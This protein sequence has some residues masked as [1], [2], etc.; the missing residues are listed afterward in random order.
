MMRKTIGLASMTL[1]VSQY[2]GP[3]TPWPE[4]SSPSEG[5]TPVTHID[6]EQVAAGLKGT[7][8]LRCLDGHYRPHED[9]IFGKVK[10]R[11]LWIRTDAIETETSESKHLCSGNWCESD[12]EK[13]GPNGETHILS[14]VEAE[15]GW[16][17]LQ[18]WGFMMVGGERRYARNIIVKKGT[19]E[20]AEIRLVYDF[21]S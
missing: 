6:I 19:K 17:A 7:T 15:A 10:G 14:H 11:S 13:A 3:S 12:D 5:S 1:Q 4:Q 2:E 9:W 20:R 16:T 18:I 21:V 8:E